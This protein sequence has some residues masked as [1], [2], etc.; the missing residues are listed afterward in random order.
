MNKGM[1]NKLCYSTAEINPD[2]C[3]L[4]PQPVER[5]NYTILFTEKITVTMY[6]YSHI[7]VLYCLKI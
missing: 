4:D 7:N 6:V 3:N 5:Y 2:V 1:Y